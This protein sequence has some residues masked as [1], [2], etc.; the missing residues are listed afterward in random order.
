MML[1]HNIIRIDNNEKKFWVGNNNICSANNLWCIISNLQLT[2]TI[3]FSGKPDLYKAI[4][5]VCEGQGWVFDDMQ[6]TY[7]W[8]K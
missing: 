3:D 6:A 2:V 7:I 8:R 4:K 1:D 5:E